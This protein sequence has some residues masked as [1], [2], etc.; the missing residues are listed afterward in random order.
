M[1]KITADVEVLVPDIASAY[2]SRMKV[3]DLSSK[4]ELAIFENAKREVELAGI[5]LK[6]QSGHRGSKDGTSNSGRH[7]A[8][9]GK[10]YPGSP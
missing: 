4:E 1:S 8:G 7:H 9:C 5:E 2:K 6:E 10:A 3:A